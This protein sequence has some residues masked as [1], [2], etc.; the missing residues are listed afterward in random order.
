MVRDMRDSVYCGMFLFM[1]FC[2]CSVCVSA[3]VRSEIY[4]MKLKLIKKL[5]HEVN[6]EYIVKLHSCSITDMEP[7]LRRA[8][9]LSYRMPGISN[10]VRWKG[11]LPITSG[12]TKLPTGRSAFQ[13]CDWFSL[14]SSTFLRF[15]KRL[16]DT[17]LVNMKKRS[18]FTL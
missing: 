6:Y 18:F 11:M 14:N 1:Q 10:S 16:S 4:N 13:R 7:S 17:I 3:Y 12:V 5:Q 9:S 8:C 15:V 2:V